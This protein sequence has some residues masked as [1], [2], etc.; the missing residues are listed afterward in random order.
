MNLTKDDPIIIILKQS[1]VKEREY[2]EL[3]KL[4]DDFYQLLHAEMRKMKDKELQQISDL[5]HEFIRIRHAKIIQFASVTKLNHIMDD[6]LSF[7]EKI[8]YNNITNSSEILLKNTL[9]I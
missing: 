4:D 2:S 3:S 1:S 6:K 9:K 8:F 7:E 5:L